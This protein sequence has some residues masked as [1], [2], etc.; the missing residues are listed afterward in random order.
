MQKK[1][2]VLAVQGDKLV[3]EYQMTAS[4]AIPFPTDDKGVKLRGRALALALNTA[5]AAAQDADYEATPL[6]QEIDL[7]AEPSLGLSNPDI[8]VDSDP[9]AEA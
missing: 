3:I 7:A 4:K 2:K 1:F 6:F 8:Y 9:D 5:T